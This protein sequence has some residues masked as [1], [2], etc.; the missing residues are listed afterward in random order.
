MQ[1]ECLKIDGRAVYRAARGEGGALILQPVDDHDLSVLDAQLE[2]VARRTEA[3]F[4]LAAFKVDNWN[5]DLSPWPAPPA[6]G[7]EP[8]GGHAPR[9]LG[10][11]ERT[12]L[13]ALD[14]PRYGE[15]LVAGYSLAGLFALYAARASDAFAGAAGVSPSVWLP[16]WLD[17]A[18]AHPTRAKRV[19]L[20]LGD[21]EARTRNPMMRAV[22]DNLQATHRILLD[23]GV[24]TT[25]E[26]N[27]GNHFREPEARMAKGVAWL[28][29]SRE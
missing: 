7:D 12:L 6:F 24:L 13:P 21:K 2:A 9:T 5:D 10:W 25:L 8:F 19:Y 27:P 18:A 22:A 16:G 1:L 14:A 4:T 3:P 17:F 11:V 15:T 26:W 29:G 23:Q 20:S 28:L